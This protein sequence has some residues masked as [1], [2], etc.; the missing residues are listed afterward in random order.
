M[1]TDNLISC[2]DVVDAVLADE[3]T[4]ET[5]VKNMKAF[6]IEHSELF[7]KLFVMPRKEKF[8]KTLPELEYAGETPAELARE[9]DA[10]TVTPP[11]PDDPAFLDA[12]ERART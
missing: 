12:M 4:F 2:G 9:M 6:A 7:E 10:L 3:E 5:R 1:N 11:H 8:A